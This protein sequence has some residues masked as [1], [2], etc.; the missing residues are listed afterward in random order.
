[1][2]K[3]DKTDVPDTSERNR[4]IKA[5][6]K[7][8][9]EQLSF[10]SESNMPAPLPAEEASNV[11]MAVEIQTE[12][13]DLST[14]TKMSVFSDEHNKEGLRIAARRVLSVMSARDV[15]SVSN[16]EDEQEEGSVDRLRKLPKVVNGQC[17]W[18]TLSEADKSRL[19]G[20]NQ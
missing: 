20:N 9:L 16:R 2:S 14:G 19:F 13:L 6:A 10:H 11:D 1:M 8:R 5:K 7:A 3:S 4:V 17:V 12:D 18:E 15:S